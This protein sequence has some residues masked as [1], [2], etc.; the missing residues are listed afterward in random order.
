MNVD[1]ATE[2]GITVDRATLGQMPSVSADAPLEARWIV[3]ELNETAAKV[4]QA[5]RITVSTTRRTRF[6]NCSGAAFAI[7]TSKS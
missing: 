3:A 5:L 2:L 1:R 4:N 7:G 6:I